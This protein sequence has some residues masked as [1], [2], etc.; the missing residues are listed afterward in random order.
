M[1]LFIKKKDDGR[2]S[3]VIRDGRWKV[4]DQGT[5]YASELGGAATIDS[6]KVIYAQV[7]RASSSQKEKAHI[8]ACIHAA[9]NAR[10]D[11]FLPLERERSTNSAPLAG[12][13]RFAEPRGGGRS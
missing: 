3:V 10:L 4:P 11:E 6:F 5:S 7:N 13:W 1:P 2:H 9:M 12:A 8:Y